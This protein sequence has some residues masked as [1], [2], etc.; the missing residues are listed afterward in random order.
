M[1]YDLHNMLIGL[2]ALCYDYVI[3][4]CSLYNFVCDMIPYFHF[5]DFNVI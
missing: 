5:S 4:F 3:W 2:R 1:P